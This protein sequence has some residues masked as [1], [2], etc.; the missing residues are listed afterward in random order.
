MGNSST[1]TEIEVLPAADLVALID[2]LAPR[3]VVGYGFY[4]EERARRRLPWER[5]RMLEV[6]R[7]IRNLTTVILVPTAVNVIVVALQLMAD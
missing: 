1:L 6:T 7:T 3:T 2:A 5:A 4:H